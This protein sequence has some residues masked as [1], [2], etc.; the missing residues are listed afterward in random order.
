M[1]TSPAPTR[2][3]RYPTQGYARLCSYVTTKRNQGLGR[4]LTGQQAVDSR[5]GCLVIAARTPLCHTTNNPTIPA[6]TQGSAGLW[7]GIPYHR[8]RG[9]H[10][11]RSAG[12]RDRHR[13]RRT[14][15]PRRAHG[16]GRSAAR[17]FRRLP[18]VGREFSTDGNRELGRRRVPRP[19]NDGDTGC[20]SSHRVSR[21]TRLPGVSCR[22]SRAAAHNCSPKQRGHRRGGR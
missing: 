16:S 18:A 5:T 17:W 20:G 22:W 7:L 1:E 10:F 21:S 11:D 15:V 9:A 6:P 4:R 2:E 13:N 3:I 12:H 14:A 19:P 8:L